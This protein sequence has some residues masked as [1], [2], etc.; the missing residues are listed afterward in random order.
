MPDKE[1][2]GFGSTIY[3]VQLTNNL[4]PE[5]QNTTAIVSINLE[6]PNG[7]GSRSVAITL[8]ASF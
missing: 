4:T 5:D 8:N 2:Y 1:N 6:S 3:Q 7:S